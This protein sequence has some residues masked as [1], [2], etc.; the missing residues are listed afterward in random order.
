MV[1]AGFTGKLLDR[2]LASGWYRMGPRMFTC[3]Y[4]FYATGFL[5]TVW[6]R[7]PL[8]GHTFPKR[9][10]KLI[11]RCEARFTYAV[12]PARATDAEEAVFAAYR[13]TKDYDLHHSAASYLRHDP[14]V[15]FDTYQVSVFD[16]DRLIAFSYFDRGAA[17][18]Q[19]VCG[20]YDPAYA[21]YSLGLYTLTAEVTQAKGWGMAY[22]YAGY[23]V[24]GNDVFEYKRRVGALEAFDD[25]ARTWYPL[26]EMD[27]GE[28]PDA[29]QRAA[30]VEYDA[31]YRGAGKSYG[32]RFKPSIQISFGRSGMS[33]LR[34]EQFPFCVVDVDSIGDT[35]WACH[36]YSYNYGRYFTLLCTHAHEFETEP[37]PGRYLAPG[38]GGD[39]GSERPFG[40][41]DRYDPGT[42]VALECLYYSSYPYTPADLARLR[43]V[44]ARTNVFGV[45]ASR[46]KRVPPGE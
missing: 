36:F 43:A 23:L 44:V 45:G 35:Y 2:Y 14:D 31:L 24:P 41:F 9:V 37:G 15:P 21:H 7:L 11:R 34:R 28:L 30:L 29:V 12:H 8:A 4:N 38:G 19:S 33:W 39:P 25:V 26:A 18:V 42:G 3:R 1:N 6:T 22:H 10:R 16:G 20:Y 13:A 27:P 40:L 32:L 5:T 46:R 17:S